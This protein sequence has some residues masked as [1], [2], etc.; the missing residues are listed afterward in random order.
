MV[1]KNIHQNEYLA[2]I[3]YYLHFQYNGWFFFACMGLLFS[4]LNLKSVR[5]YFIGRFLSCFLW[6]VFP[7]ISYRRFGG[8]CLF[9]YIL[10]VIA[11]FIQVN[12][13]FRFLLI[14][15]KTN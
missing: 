1:T 12:T 15:V 3:Y 9:L 2:S 7:R 8:T 10:S 5:T 4:M 6:L 13:W 14:I 11:A